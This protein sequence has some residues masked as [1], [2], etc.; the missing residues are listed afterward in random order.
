MNY[1][2]IQKILIK[3]QK[4]AK[5]ITLDYNPVNRNR[6]LIEINEEMKKNRVIKTPDILYFFSIIRL[7]VCVFTDMPITI[8]IFETIILKLLKCFIKL[9]NL[10][11]YYLRKI[12]NA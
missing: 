6:Q 4:H 3:L 10:Q 5:R 8:K 9:Y 7:N 12:L 1:A 11:S 2:N